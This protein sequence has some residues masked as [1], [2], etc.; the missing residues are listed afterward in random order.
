LLQLPTDGVVF[1]I[2]GQ[3]LVDVDFARYRRG[4]RQ[5]DNRGRLVLGHVGHDGQRERLRGAVST[6]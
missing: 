6:G 1:R 3:R 2:I 4:A 5:G